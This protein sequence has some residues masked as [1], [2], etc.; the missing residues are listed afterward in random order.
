MLNWGMI[1]R[2]TLDT[3]Y[4]EMRMR[5]SSLS[6]LIVASLSLSACS[7][8]P[9]FINEY[10]IDVQ[11]GNVLS[12]D[13]VAQLKPG[14]TRDQ[15]RFILGTPLITDIF[16]RDRWDYVYRF[17]DGRTGEVQSRR[18]SVFFDPDD[19]LSRV[20]GDVEVASVEEL[21]LPEA[22]MR[23]MDLGNIGEAGATSEAPPPEA[24]GF[25]RRA[26]NRIGF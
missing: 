21:T 17:R 16:H 14:Q 20:E 12:Q 15:V 19:R 11:Q 18:L 6:L 13:M 3:K 8:K 5:R 9:G 2:F 22:R 1:Y 4:P 23:V 25:F 10:R 7:Y 24:P 26:L